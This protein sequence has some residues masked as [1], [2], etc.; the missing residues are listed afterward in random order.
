MSGIRL[1]WREPSHNLRILVGFID[2]SV[3]VGVVT[4]IY[5]R[6]VNIAVA[7][8][9]YVCVCVRVCSL[10][11]DALSK[12][13]V[14]SRNGRGI[15]SA[16]RGVYKNLLWRKLKR[17]GAIKL[18]FW[19]LPPNHFMP[20]KYEHIGIVDPLLRPESASGITA[21]HCADSCCA[22][23]WRSC[24]IYDTATPLKCS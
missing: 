2:G 19:Q 16:N 10:G 6:A 18:I 14:V 7:V 15:C 22:S 11:H 9:N 8:C 5:G 23:I 20:R 12:I 4:I 17:S 24:V 1:Y 21:K 13:S 3:V